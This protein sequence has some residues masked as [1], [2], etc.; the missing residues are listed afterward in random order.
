MN[1][2]RGNQPFKSAN[3]FL[4]PG[5][6]DNL[7][8]TWRLARDPR[9]APM[10]KLIVPIAIVLYLISPIDLVPDFLFG[11]GQID[12]LGLIGVA[13]LITFRLL[14][15][16]APAEVVSQHLAELGLRRDDRTEAAGF[17]RTGQDFVDASFHVHENPPGRS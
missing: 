6:I 7:R 8:L 13:L 10:Y 1:A 11:I 3:V 12:D 5:A 2:R 15:R 4:E 14:P 9:V 16:L 17:T